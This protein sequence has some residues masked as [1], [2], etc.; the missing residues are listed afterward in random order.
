MVFEG[1]TELKLIKASDAFPSE[2]T[3]WVHGW[4]LKSIGPRWTREMEPSFSSSWDAIG[5]KEV[6]G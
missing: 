1:W 4:S 6:Q 3:P 5:D 2:E